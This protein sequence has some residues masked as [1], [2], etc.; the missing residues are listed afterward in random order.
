MA[1]NIVHTQ[2]ENTGK[3]TGWHMLFIMLSAFGVIITVNMTL[4]VFAVYSWTGLVVKNTY[5]AS[6][7]Y[8]QLLEENAQQKRRGWEGELSQT[9]NRLVFELRNKQKL[10]IRDASVYADVG[11]PAH[12]LDDHVIKFTAEG[13]GRF[14]APNALKAGLW[15]IKLTAVRQTGERYRKDFRITVSSK[16]LSEGK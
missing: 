6:Q 16:A 5:V 3:F 7:K 2:H 11:R 13:K 4:A 14:V 9:Q 1:K 8:N 12:E 15:D 10:P